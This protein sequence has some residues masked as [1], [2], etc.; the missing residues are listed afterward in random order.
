MSNFLTA[1][2]EAA[3]QALANSSEFRTWCGATSVADALANYIFSEESINP[4]DLPGNYAVI[5][6]VE[7]WE[8]ARDGEGSGQANFLL[9]SGMIKVSFLESLAA[10]EDWTST[11][12]KAFKDFIWNLIQ[13]F[14]NDYESGTFSAGFRLNAIRKIPFDDENGRL[15]MSDDQNGLKMWMYSWELEIG[16]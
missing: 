5:S 7:D 6:E 2:I 15:R 13:P 14:I 3:E 1:S 8:Y 10:G 12:R 4:E 11:N 16:I 9:S